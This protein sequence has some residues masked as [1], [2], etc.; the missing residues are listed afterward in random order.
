MTRFLVIGGLVVAI[1]AIAIIGCGPRAQVAKDSIIKKLDSVLGELNVKRAKIEQ[2]RSKLSDRLDN[3][4]EQRYRAEANRD[5]MKG[6]VDKSKAELEK[7]LGRVER[8]KELITQIKSSESGTIE[9]NGRQVTADEVQKAAEDAASKAQTEKTKLAG[10]ESSYQAIDKSVKFLKD[11]EDQVSK[12][13]D[14]FAQKINEIDAKKIAVDAVRQASSTTG[15][16]SINDDMAKL[17]KEI[18]ELGIDIEAALRMETDKMNDLRSA[19]SDV[20]DILTAPADLNAA[21]Q[22]LDDLLKDKE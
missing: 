18:E 15:D 1:A 10:Y 11:Q 14:S 4:K 17:E 8:A 7:R 6:K 13:M 21:E 5:N 20:S 12:M 22:L 19:S 2:E 16:K 3:V 9:V